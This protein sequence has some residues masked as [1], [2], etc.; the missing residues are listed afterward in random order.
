MSLKTKIIITI[1]FIDLF[2]NLV[3]NE[4]FTLKKFTS[5]IWTY[6][7]IIFNFKWS[8]VGFKSTWLLTN[9]HF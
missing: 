9:F 1:V 8:S 3:N 2:T 5:Y 6:I 7:F 4:G